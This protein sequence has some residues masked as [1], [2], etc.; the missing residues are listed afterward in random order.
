MK[1]TLIAALVLSCSTV[2]AAEYRCPSAYPGKDAPATLLTGAMMMFGERPNNGLLFPPGWDTPN[3]FAVEGGMDLHHELPE[4]EEGWLICEYGSG[5]RV[6]G[7]YHGGKE[8]GQSMEHYGQQSW[9][10][11]L[12]PKD[13]SCTIHIREVKSHQPS[14]WTVT[15]TCKGQP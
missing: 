3:E 15:A 8:W 12:A 9:F 5:K 4:N 10:V 14:T 13:R 11:K 1:Q 7:R 2:H 6:K